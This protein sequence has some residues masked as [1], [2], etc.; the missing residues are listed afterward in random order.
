MAARKCK[1]PRQSRPIAAFRPL[2]PSTSIALLD[3]RSVGHPLDEVTGATIV[4][5]GG[6][7]PRR[8]HRE[9]KEVTSV[10]HT[11]R[12]LSSIACLLAFAAAAGAQELG[13]AQP[14]GRDWRGEMVRVHARFHGRP[15]TFAH[16]G[17]SITETL[18]FWTPLKH[19]RKDAPPEME[20]RLPAGRGPP[21]PGMLA[22][23]EGPGIRQPGRPDDPLGRGKRRGLAGA[24][25]PGGSPG[26]VRHERPAATWRSTSTGI[27]CGRSSGNAWTTG[28]S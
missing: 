6:W 1:A 20:R 17:D 27:G 11:G 15:G 23:L 10:A 5:E 12:S 24:A 18:A 26:H 14:E 22:G 8:V 4:E 3:L 13:P 19:A 7:G 21:A 16:F 28:R 2:P 25:Q 9:R